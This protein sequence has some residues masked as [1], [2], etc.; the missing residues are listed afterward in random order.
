M[1]GGPTF[2]PGGVPPGP[3]RLTQASTRLLHEWSLTQTFEAGPWYEL[4]L[5]PTPLSVA[6]PVV[7]PEIDGMLRRAN[8]YADLVG[9]TPKEIQVVE[10]KMVAE[11]GAISQLEHYIDL[12]HTTPYI[13]QYP[14]RVVQGVLLFAVGD[15]IIT[16]R[17]HAR[18]LRV[19]VWTP[20]WT[21]DY[22]A[23]KYYRR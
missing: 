17:A 19:V 18:G 3:R 15:A 20:A 8:R 13:Q 21:Q 7:T 2:T 14:G 22:L 1:I 23:Q 4:R 10:A 16:Q 9:I 6:A 12:V 11:P 5:G